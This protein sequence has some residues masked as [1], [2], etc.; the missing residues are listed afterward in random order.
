MGDCHMKMD[1][2]E[3]AVEY[4]YVIAEKYSKLFNMD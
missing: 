3:K 1:N 2:L 4:Y